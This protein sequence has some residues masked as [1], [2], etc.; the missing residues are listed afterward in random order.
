MKV[1]AVAKAVAAFGDT[2]GGDEGDRPLA[3]SI[4][5]EM[6]P[7]QHRAASGV[8]MRKSTLDTTNI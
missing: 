6:P 5:G 2:E 1:A 7:A 3:G 4:A 8:R